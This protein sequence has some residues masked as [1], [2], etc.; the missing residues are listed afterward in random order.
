MVNAVLPLDRINEAF[1]L[2]HQGEVIR[3]V[4]RY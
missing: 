4:I 1:D 3:S 2:M